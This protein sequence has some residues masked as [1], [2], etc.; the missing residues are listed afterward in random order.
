MSLSRIQC[1]DHHLGLALFGHQDIA[2][3]KHVVH[4]VHDSVETAGGSPFLGEPD[5]AEL[6]AL[7]VLDDCHDFGC[8]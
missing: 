4:R 6:A 1:L 5:N 2:L 7:A 3:L 8:K